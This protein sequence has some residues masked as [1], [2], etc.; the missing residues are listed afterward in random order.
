MPFELEL[1]TD[2]L[3]R[4]I[5]VPKI[6]QKDV[7]V[8]YAMAMLS[9]EETDWRRVNDA[10]IA[11]WSRSGLERVKIMAHKIWGMEGK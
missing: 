4:E 11:R 9:S 5:A 8:V 1:C 7:A 3:L 2:T 6:R 10:I